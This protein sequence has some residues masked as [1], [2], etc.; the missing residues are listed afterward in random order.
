[1][2]LRTRSANIAGAVINSNGI[3]TSSGLD[4]TS[5]ANLAYNQANTAYGQANAA[6]N[7][8]N[9]AFAHANVVFAHAN[10]AYDQANLAYA[11]ANNSNLK[12]G[13][14][15]SGTINVTNDMIVGGNIYL[16]GN[17]TFINVSTYQ[18]ND[19]LL[20]IAANNELTDSVDI[21][22]MGGKNTSGTYSHTGLARDATDGKWKL[23]DGLPEEGHVG[24]VINFA[25]TYLATL[26]ANVEANT[27]SVV[28]GVSGNVNFDSGTLFVDSVGNRVGI[29]TA[30]PENQ[31]RLVIK[32]AA[33]SVAGGLAVQA[34]A[35]DSY[36][37]IWNSGS[38]FNI[39]AYYNS[40][41]SYQPITFRTSNS[42]RMRIDTSGRVTIGN[43]DGDALFGVYQSTDGVAAAR[44][45]GPTRNMAIIPYYNSE[46]NNYGTWMYAYNTSG[47]AFN[48]LT[49]G[50][51][52][53]TIINPTG[54]NVAIGTTTAS[55]KLTVN[56]IIY[57]S[58]GGI[59]FP[60]G[61]TQNTA[62][63]AATGTPTLNVI[64]GSA[65][66]AVKDNHYVL[67]S[68]SLTTVT[69]PAS[70]SAGDVVWVTI[71]NGRVDNVIA[72]NGQNINSLAE[73][74]TVDVGYVGIQLRY[75]D[76]TRG[77]VFSS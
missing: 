31:G 45:R 32:Q 41:G 49:I 73:D 59:R 25:N 3:V 66:T 11:A 27:L 14:L 76:A 43:T 24:N 60:D 56:G 18:V 77:W 33:S 37:G 5:Q 42:E 17:T 34:Q 65:V 48:R 54:G 51:S 52:A 69:L 46:G 35:N 19:S 72:R 39:E 1:M 75:A 55:Y 30:N 36:L 44:F 68:A 9:G 38:E 29:G 2:T 21:G 40:T 16:Q 7:H 13:G 70:P 61:T 4:I 50:A 28:N 64:T 57:S 63:V 10:S 15:I 58:S 26:V 6:F 74:M 71:A 67:V 47:G 20:Y 12:S 22:F 23:F 8:A 53:E 62:A